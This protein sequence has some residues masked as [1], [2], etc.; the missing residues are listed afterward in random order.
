MTERPLRA[1]GLR[2][3]RLI[4]NEVIVSFTTLEPH[5]YQECKAG[6]RNWLQ[7]VGQAETG[8]SLPEILTRIEAADSN[9]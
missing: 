4:Q 7:P 8:V 6:S 9:S 1:L 2:H 5:R 3:W